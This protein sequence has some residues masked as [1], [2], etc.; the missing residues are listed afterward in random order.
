[1][2]AKERVDRWLD[3]ALALRADFVAIQPDDARRTAIRSYLAATSQLIDLSGRL[4]FVLMEATN[5]AAFRFASQPPERERLIDLCIERK[6]AIGAD[7][8]SVA[9]FD[10]PA[11]S[12]NRAQPATPE[13]KAK[14]LK[15]IAATRQLD[16]VPRVAEFARSLQ[17]TPPLGRGCGRDLARS[18]DAAGRASRT[19]MR[20]DCPSR[21]ITP[22]ELHELLAKIPDAQLSADEDA[23]RDELV[24]WLAVMRAR[25]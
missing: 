21:P 15:L 3:E 16:L 8:M 7:V 13:V 24:A 25:V 4:R 22:R 2:L 20:K 17:T 19:R 12:T 5:F 23:R 1:M 11:N 6:S 10:P 9:L 14:L 18:R